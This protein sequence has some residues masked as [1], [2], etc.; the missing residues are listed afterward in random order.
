MFEDIP[1]DTRHLEKK[2]KKKKLGDLRFPVEWY[3]PPNQQTEQQAEL[4][5]QTTSA[6][7]ITIGNDNLS[8]ESRKVE[9]TINIK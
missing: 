1:M 3:R 5:D 7:T 6:T 8:E 2:L 4:L 9:E